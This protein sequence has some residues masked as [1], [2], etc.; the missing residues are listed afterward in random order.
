ML[1]Y[2]ETGEGISWQKEKRHFNSIKIKISK[3]KAI[4]LNIKI[5]MPIFI[6]NYISWLYTLTP[7]NDEVRKY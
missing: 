2:Y 5:P 4:L 6:E 1:R 3:I 7:H